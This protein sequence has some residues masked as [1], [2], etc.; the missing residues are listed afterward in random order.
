MLN[1]TATL[2]L[3]SPVALAAQNSAVIS[4]TVVGGVDQQPLRYSTV[5]LEG[6][7]QKRLT[8]PEGR[9]SFRVDT[10]G[11]YH[12][13]I[14]QLGFAP[15][16]TVIEFNGTNLALTLV[17][18]PV[19]FKLADVRT[20]GKT[21]CARQIDRDAFASGVLEEVKKN[22]EREMVLRHQYPFRYSLAVVRGARRDTVYFSSATND[23]YQPG[24][25]TR[26]S[27]RGN[28]NDMEMRVPQ[29]TDLADSVFL[30]EHCFS[31]GGTHKLGKHSVFRLD[32]TP[33]RSVRTPDVE[34]TISIDTADY[35]VK[36]AIF[37]MTNPELLNPPILGLEVRTT[38]KEI[39]PGLTLFDRVRSEQPLPIKGPF[40]A[41]RLAIEEQQL[42]RLQFVR[43]TPSGIS[44]FA[45]R[46]LERRRDR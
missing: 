16:D 19:A 35:T 12:L 32:F 42:I 2:I 21:P 44:E 26:P 43:D 38:Y 11:K 4:G 46:L 24:R 40:E 17:L 5:S 27:G 9:F 30:R 1:R 34:G 18:R 37:R 8:S 25:L 45:M 29:L 36:E 31:Y 6:I 14:R 23:R 39:V 20:V 7:T 22:A 28:P 33:A 41:S 3:L 13:R 15:L 10:A